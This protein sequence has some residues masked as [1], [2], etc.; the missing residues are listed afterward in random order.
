MLDPKLRV[1]VLEVFLDLGSRGSRLPR[2]ELEHRRAARRLAVHCARL[3]VFRSAGGSD[4]VANRTTLS[5]WHHLRGV[6]AGVVRCTGTALDALRFELG[7]RALLPP[8]LSFA[9]GERLVG[10]DVPPGNQGLLN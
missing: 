6:H 3:L 9:P 2:I 7:V 5:A 8:L 4:D 1:V 10:A